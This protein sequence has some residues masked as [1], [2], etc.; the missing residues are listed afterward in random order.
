MGVNNKIEDT[1]QGTIAT[2][3]DLGVRIS[4]DR[5]VSEISYTRKTVNYTSA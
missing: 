5:K 4:V 3:N 1:V 2:E